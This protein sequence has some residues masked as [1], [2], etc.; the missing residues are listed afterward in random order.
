MLAHA[1]PL[2]RRVDVVVATDGRRAE[3]VGAEVRGLLISHGL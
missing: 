3:H 2:L 1:I